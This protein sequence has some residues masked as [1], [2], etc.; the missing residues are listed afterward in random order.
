MD[1]SA[2]ILWTQ[3]DHRGKLRSNIC[4][5]VTAR[6]DCGPMLTRAGLDP[7]EDAPEQLLGHRHLRPLERTMSRSVCKRC[8]CWGPSAPQKLAGVAERA[9]RAL[10]PCL[11]P[12]PEVDRS[13]QH[14]ITRVA[15]SIPSQ[16]PTERVLSAPNPL[17]GPACAITFI[18]VNILRSASV[19][20]R[21]SWERA[22]LG[23]TLRHSCSI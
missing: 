22:D 18:C 23:V 14:P 13:G 11:G 20:I 19:N 9:G 2:A 15:M 17:R 8:P 3:I 1:A 10:W 16:P 4:S 12:I 6:P 7:I 21:G 5:F